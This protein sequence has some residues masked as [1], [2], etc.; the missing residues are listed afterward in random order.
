MNPEHFKQLIS[1]YLTKKG[2]PQNLAL[3]YEDVVLIDQY[4]EI[5]SRADITDTKT[6]IARSVF[7]NAPVISSNM[8]T[9]TEYQMAIAV[10]RAGGIGTI[11]QFLSPEEKLSQIDKVKRADGLMI[12]RLVT[13]TE[14]GKLRHARNLMIENQI[15]GLL[16]TDSNGKLTNILTNRDI[17]FEERQDILIK[18]FLT[19]KK[20][21]IAPQ[22]I[23][24]SE[25]K[26][27]LVDHL[28]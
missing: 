7:I 22:N 5:K 9:V 21:L 13:I 28:I 10:A 26:K 6:E 25:A 20:V 4:S 11:H 14:T 16:I 18:D 23:D 19:P 12:E 2:L 1:D 27:L 8:A 24:V 15:S 3:A 17:Q